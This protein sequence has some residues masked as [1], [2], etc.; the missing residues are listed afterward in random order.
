MR[1]PSRIA[2][3]GLGYVG[4]PLAVALARRYE[5]V[6]FDVSGRRIA[7]LRDG[8]DA[9]RE[10]EAA[11]LKACRAVFTDD[12]AALKGADLHIV[13]VPTPVDEANN[14]DLSAVLAACAAV[15]AALT[16]GATVVLESTVYPGVTEDICGPALEKASGLTAGRDFFLGYSPERINPGD[17]THTLARIKKVVA[18]Q[19]PEITAMLARVYGSVTEAGVFEAVSIKT[20]EAAKVIENAQ[21]DINIAFINEV[22]IIFNRMGLSIYDVLEAAGTKWNF[23]KF[24]PGLVG[25]HCIGVDP[26]YLAHLAQRL[27]HHP[28]VVLAGR[29]TNDGMGHYIAACVDRAVAER[30]RAAG[31]APAPARILVLGLTFKEN[32][33]DLRNTKV[34]D[35]VEDLRARGHAVDVCDPLADRDE[36]M[37]LYGLEL[38]VTP[39]GAAYDC[40]LGAVPHDAYRAF[41]GAAFRRLLAPG[42]LVA[43]VKGMWR[44]VALPA[45]LRRWDL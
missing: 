14:P 33:P 34:I 44:A 27:G 38:H 40:V 32:V 2:V 8:I 42:G 13:T 28:E 22:A 4:L 3:I 30:R 20:A 21:R 18:G 10:V 23:L 25:G 39:P 12:P 31:A 17:R 6:G 9:T 1:E 24:T 11:E 45:D 16:K 37:A 7:A 26:Y 36:A 5:V 43:D 29:R 19:T 15:G 35:I 41:D